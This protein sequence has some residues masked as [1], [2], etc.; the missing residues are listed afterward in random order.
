[1]VQGHSVTHLD[2]SLNTQA[3]FLHPFKLSSSYHLIKA[4]RK[5]SLHW[6][7]VN[8]VTRLQVRHA[9]VSRS[10]THSY[11]P[12]RSLTAGAYSEIHIHSRKSY[13]VDRISHSFHLNLIENC[14]HLA[15]SKSISQ[16]NPMKRQVYSNFR[17]DTVTV[18]REYL[19]EDF[20]AVRNNVYCF[21]CSCSDLKAILA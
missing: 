5:W 16:I 3:N 11:F 18:N 20:V 1:M 14:L 17:E 19:L 9:T 12:L 21:Y 13:S 6:L 8:L 2:P 7:E 10:L 15:L 4:K